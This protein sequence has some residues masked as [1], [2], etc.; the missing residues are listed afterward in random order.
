MAV[1]V[2]PSTTAQPNPTALA[3]PS[4][5]KSLAK[6]LVVA[7]VIAGLA[8][9]TFFGL[10]AIFHMIAMGSIVA[11]K[12]GLEITG[13]AAATTAIIGA[14]CFAFEHNMFYDTEKNLEETG[15]FIRDTIL[16]PFHAIAGL[17]SCVR[18]HFS[19]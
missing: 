4:F 7:A 14:H 10:G 6:T 15:A 1:S 16:T 8:T 3:E 13:V 2:Q 11:W 18:S 17:V 19:R 9:G 5:A 12:L